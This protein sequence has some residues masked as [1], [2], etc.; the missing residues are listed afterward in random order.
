MKNFTT[1][2]LKGFSLW[3]VLMIGTF[4]HAQDFEWVSQFGG[5]DNE[6]G[7]DVVADDSGNVYSTG[8]FYGTSDFDPSVG[9]FDLTSPA[10]QDIYVSKLDVNGD[11]VWAH[12][13][14]NIERNRG[15]A[16]TIDKDT[17]IYI[18][19]YFEGTVDFDPGAG[20]EE[21]TS[22]G[23]VDCF[24]LKLN[25]NGAFIWVKHI[26]GSG[27]E[28]SLDLHVDNDGNL[29][30]SGYMTAEADFD[31]DGAGL[32]LT[33]TGARDPFILKLDE[34]GNTIWLNQ[35]EGS[36]DGYPSGI[37]TDN[38][39][40]VYNTG[41]FAGDCDFD[42]SPNNSI[43][44][45]NG[46]NDIYIVKFDEMGTY[47]WSRSVGST[48]DD[49]SND[50]V[51]NDTG[52]V[53]MTGQFEQTVDFDPSTGTNDLVAQGGIESFLWSLN[54][55]GDFLWANAIGG[56]GSDLGFDLDI[57]GNG[58]L[59]SVGYFS[60]VSTFDI[61]NQL[62]SAGG[63]DIYILKTNFN[64]NLIWVEQMGGTSDDLAIGL[65]VSTNWD[66]HVTGF[67]QGT[68]DFDPTNTNTQLT[69]TDLRDA[70]V[71][72]MSQLCV[73][74]IQDSVLASDTLLCP[75]FGLS[76]QLVVYGELNDA[77]SWEW[78]T[79][80]C[81]EN[82]ISSGDTV[83]F[84]PTSTT[85]YYVRAEGG[86][87]VLPA[88]DSITIYVDDIEAPIA[89]AG[90]LNDI[91][92]LCEVTEL[93]APTA[94][95]N[96]SGG[97]TGTHNA[98]LPI[99]SSTTVTW[100]YEDAAGNTS[101]QDHEVIIE[102]VDVTVSVDEITLTANNTTLGVFYRWVDCD[103][104]FAPITNATNQSFTPNVNGNYAVVIL[105]DDCQ[106]T[107]ACIEVSTVGLEDFNQ[108]DFNV[109]PN[110]STGEFSIESP[111]TE[112]ISYTITDNAGRVVLEGTF[113]EFENTIDLSTEE[114]GIYFLRVEGSVMKLIVQ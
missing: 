66:V 33:S 5:M 47:N 73:Q 15:N 95:D 84:T 96:C 40:N 65:D 6:Y 62:T 59:Y 68:A 41:F 67:F 4:V 8:Y 110:P 45:S 63:N 46:G 29:L 30:A 28:E 75:G 90:P 16:I 106:D 82:W 97:V 57:D 86:C 85:T 77:A 114:Q 107:S 26:G 35:L 108:S 83:D 55:T 44:T 1:L 109:Y 54:S 50:V 43:K 80:G 3:T 20:V 34:N 64:G 2:I 111:N 38:N 42:P 27:A 9:T 21:K 17:N 11:F 24:I 53:F 58:G 60:G 61:T 104:N 81:G 72:K 14:G 105:Q 87:G 51:V 31:L 71:Y 89:D 39:N 52:Q 48:G 56:T 7:Q 10:Q 99:T 70:Y 98:V 78:Y 93:T 23:I 76:S 103:D 22:L 102:G 112:A 25:K 19:G 94:T 12:R 92:G 37:Y 88:C 32:V 91:T 79:N 36:G 13:F 69:S 74:P 49:R 113:E 18:S 101:T 100:T